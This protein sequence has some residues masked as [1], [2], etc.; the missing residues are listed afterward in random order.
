MTERPLATALLRPR[1]VALVGASGDP[2][3]P[4]GRV[5]GYLR[6]HGYTAPVWPINPRRRKILGEPALATLADL[7]EAVDHAY[8]LVAAEAVAAAVA[9]CG[10]RGIGCASILAGGFAEG[11]AAGAALQDRL[12]ATARDHGVRL[13]GPNSMGVINVSDR[14]ALSVSAVL[15]APHLLPG[16]LGLL[17]HSGGMLG[18]LLSRG[19]ARGI[20]FSKLV[21]VGNEA[22]L[23]I[24]EIGELLVDDPATHAILMFLETIRAPARLEAMARRAADRGKP[25]VA[26]MPGRSEAG[27]EL[28]A[29]HTGALVGA[30]RSADAFL[31]DC[32]ILRVDMLETLLELPALVANRAPSEAPPKTVAV[33]TTTGGG[34]AVV[35]DR[36]ALAGLEVVPPPAAMIARLA[37]RGID[38]PPGRLT[39]LTLAGARPEVIG[40]ILEALLA[41][42]HCQA[43]V[44]VAGSSAQFR[45]DSTV[46]P[47][48]AHAGAA[49]PLAAF[50]APQADRA[51]ARLA[52][53][54]I[55]AFRTP[56]SC[57]E[58]MRALFERRPPRRLQR[59][60]VGDPARAAALLAGAELDA[61]ASLAA[62]AALG[63][64]CAD[65]RVIRDLERFGEA[66]EVDFYPAVAKILSPDLPH[67]A[68][69]GGVVLPI[70]DP[71]SLRSALR[72]ILDAVAAAAPRAKRTGILVQRLEAGVAEAIVGYR[73]DPRVGPVVMVG[74]GGALAEVYGDVAVRCAPVSSAAARAM[75]DEVRGLG[76]G[77][78]EAL[79]AAICAVSDLARVPDAGIEVAEINPLI[80]KADGQ[81]V[82]AV[83]GLVIRAEGPA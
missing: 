15:D 42:P 35:V 69:L 38:I 17:S 7:P 19:Q 62:F 27:R 73:V 23:G 5:L 25:V 10:R 44:V 1:S 78:M 40:P 83:D 37:A 59:P 51:L 47:I 71:G 68:K 60:P 16:G 50:L 61:A 77:D 6:R 36:L 22:D 76:A 56:E 33:M 39:D 72:R 54:G 9:Q 43:V 53:A 67:K 82:V 48:L 2:E 58:A 34:G 46:R 63:V 28:A 30:D 8:I 32:G 41:S 26:Y 21:S 31:R 3:K 24:A 65:S 11:G 20:G 80:V 4:A 57:A 12:L 66:A 18:T 75:I 55:A 49:K 14:V 70:P 52:A 29:A 79:A 74:S 64:A 45:P 13:L 81:G